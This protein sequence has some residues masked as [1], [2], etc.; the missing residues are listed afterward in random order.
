MSRLCERNPPTWETHLHIFLYTIQRSRK[1]WLSS[2]PVARHLRRPIMSQVLNGKYICCQKGIVVCE[3]FMEYRHER[4]EIVFEEFGD[5]L[6][7]EIDI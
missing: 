3:V 1:Y 4:S 5:I 2:F 7:I 6:A